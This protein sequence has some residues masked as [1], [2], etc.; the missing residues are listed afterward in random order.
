MDESV[1]ID[2][3]RRRL[4]RLW[5]FSP[6]RLWLL[7]IA[8][9]R[10]GYRRWAFTIKQLNSILYHN[11][12]SPGASVSPDVHLGHLSH[13]T[14]IHSDVAIGRRVTIWHNVTLAVPPSPGSDARIVIEDDAKI[15]TN[16]T[17]IPGRGRSLRIG[18]GARIGAGAVVTED[19][20][21]RATV[22]PA[23]VRVLLR[24]AATDDCAD[25][26]LL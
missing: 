19:V 7:S 1:A 14:V 24:D 17:I 9:R 26:Q 4:K 23:A 11:S 13:G 25:Q 6:E 15:G 18:R 20:P 5:V 3:L 2:L 21:A 12:L 16:V 10:R 8:L 22:V